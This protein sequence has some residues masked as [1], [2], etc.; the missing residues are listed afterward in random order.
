MRGPRKDKITRGTVPFKKM[1]MRKIKPLRLAVVIALS[2][3]AL[4]LGVAII[5]Y[6]WL[7]FKIIWRALPG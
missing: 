6:T 1:D 7:L 2:P 4:V 3:L 5:K